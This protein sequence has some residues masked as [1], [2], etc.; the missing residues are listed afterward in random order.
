MINVVIAG[1]GLMGG[2][3]A[4]CLKGKPG[5]RVIGIDRDRS[6]LEKAVKRGVVD[7]AAGSLKEAAEKA[8]FIFLCVPVGSLEP[9]LDELRQ[10]ALKPGCI[11]SD[12]GSVKGPIAAAAERLNIPGVY[13]I[14]G[15]PMAGSERSGVEAANS[16]LYENAYYVLTPAANVPDSAYS[17]LAELLKH[18]RA[19]L[20][21]LE[22]RHHD[23]IVGAISHLPH[24]IAVALVNLV[25]QYNERDALYS[26]LAAGGFRDITRIASGHPE[27]WRDIL[28]HNREV[29][30]GLLRDWGAEMNRF[31]DMLSAGDGESIAREF[32]RA[33]AF[34]RELPERRKGV[35]T[36]LY[37][38]YVDVPDHP[39]IIGQIAS[40]LGNHKINLS[41]IHIIE[42]RGEV[43]GVLRLSFRNECDLESAI[44]LLKENGYA[45]QL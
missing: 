5:I 13:F 36:S 1:V 15:H 38:V 24:I 29:I 16:H 8:D 14:G 35:I 19:H 7:E 11:I 27:M 30:L 40:L 42:S 31:A 22:P 33:G 23:Q 10:F 34:R 37:D 32:A 44:E 21:K 12:V 18:T 39:G 25:A 3:L 26:S 43:P 20:I 41:N 2:S 28:I 17:R 45:V 4:L 6:Q 9:F